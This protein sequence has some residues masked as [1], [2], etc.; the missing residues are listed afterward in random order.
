MIELEIHWRHE[1]AVRPPRIP[2]GN[3][4]E[5]FKPIKGAEYLPTSAPGCILNSK[6]DQE[7]ASEMWLKASLDLLWESSG[8][9]PTSALITHLEKF[10]F[11]SQAINPFILNRLRTNVLLWPS[12][13]EELKRNLNLQG[14]NETLG[15][16]N[17]LHNIDNYLLGNHNW[18]NASESSIDL[19]E[20]RYLIWVTQFT[21]QDRMLGWGQEDWNS[22]SPRDLKLFFAILLRYPMSFATAFYI[23][24]NQLSCEQLDHR[25]GLGGLNSIKPAVKV[26]KTL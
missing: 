19:D 23:T 21:P 4:S 17:D 25:M 26:V 18:R 8:Q 13:I 12:E 5:Q 22:I 15:Y 3:K 14:V 20:R 2:Q 9:I 7:I 10:N 1:M 24:I 6:D 16:T 11:Q